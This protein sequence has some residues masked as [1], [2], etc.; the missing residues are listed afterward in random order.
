[1]L[2]LNEF[3]EV[4]SRVAHQLYIDMI[5]ANRTDGLDHY[6]NKVG[7]TE[8]VQKSKEKVLVFG[9]SQVSNDIIRSVFEDNGYNR[10]DVVLV[11]DKKTIKAFDCGN[12]LSGKYSLI[13]LGQTPHKIKGMDCRYRSI[14][15]EIMNNKDKYHN[16][17]VARNKSRVRITKESLE[18]ILQFRVCGCAC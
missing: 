2:G 3:N 15:G 4:Y 8:A 6:L 1:M 14:L 11:T 7:K 5:Y 13:I 10:D 18:E 17:F 12:L 16:V 9:Y